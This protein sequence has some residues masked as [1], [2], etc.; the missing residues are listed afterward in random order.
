VLA[1]RLRFCNEESG[2][3]CEVRG[4]LRRLVGLGAEPAEGPA[5][6]LGT[7]GIDKSP[8]RRF[9]LARGFPDMRGES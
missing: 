2:S 7:A 1:S 8:G 6:W 9:L 3:G 4:V 5:C